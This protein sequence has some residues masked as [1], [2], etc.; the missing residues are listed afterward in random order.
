TAENQGSETV[1]DKGVLVQAQDSVNVFI[2]SF[3]NFT[4]DLTQVLPEGSLGDDYRVDA[5]HGLPNF[6]DLHK[7]EL[8]IVATQDGTQVL[9][10]PSVNT[11]GGR[12]AGVP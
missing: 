1:R 6:G 2:S 3:Q 11:L 10:T 4:H 8:L 12:P 7:S 5:Y 9:I